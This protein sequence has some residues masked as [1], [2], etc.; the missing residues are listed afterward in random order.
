MVA[1]GSQILR[2][3]KPPGYVRTDGVMFYFLNGSLNF[4]GCT[5]CSQSN[6]DDVPTT[7]LTC[8]G[9]APIAG[10][11]MGSAI[12]GNVLWAQCTA[13]GTYWDAGSD[14]ADSRGTP[15]SRG[16]LIFQDHANTTQPAFTGSGQ[17]SFAGGMYFHSNTYA[18]VLSL[19][20]GTSSGTYIL[21]EIITDQVSLTGSG[22]IKLAL[23]PQA[24]TNMAKVAILQ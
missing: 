6:V 11:G 16:L 10:L 20:G 8:D 19:S 3:A 15:G 9:S 13:S 14:T 7:D 2:V 24:T 22:M 17:L 18:D 23:N 21:G 1:G 4:S 5:G 12:G